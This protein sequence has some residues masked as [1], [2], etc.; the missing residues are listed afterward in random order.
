MRIVIDFLNAPMLEPHHLALALGLASMA[1]EHELWIAASSD[2]RGAFDTLRLS[3]DGLV[4]RHH[5][6]PFALSDDPRLNALLR[7]QALTSLVPD[8]VVTAGT[9]MAAD[10]Q[11]CACASVSLAGTVDELWQRVQD[12]FAS[13]FPPS[14]LRTGAKPR[15]AYVSPLP[16][17]KSGIADYAAELVPELAAYYDI[18]LIVEQER[19]ADARIE[20][21]AQRSAAWLR[22]HARSYDRVLYH[23][24]NSPVHRHMFELIRDVP[25]VVVLHDFYLSN[26]I[27]HLE[28]VDYLPQGF[29][30]ALYESH[31]YSG[32]ADYLKLGRHAAVWQYPL[33]KG[34]LD[35]ATGVIIHSE[36]PKQLAVEWYGDGAA[37]G[38]RSIPLLRGKPEGAVLPQA[39]SAARNRLGLKSGHYVVCSFGMLGKT[40]LNDD[41]L[42]AFLASPLAADPHCSLIFVGENEQGKYGADLNRKIR[43]SKCADRIKITGFVDPATYADYLAGC[44]SAV[45]LRGSSRGETSAAVLDCLLYGVPTIVNAHGSTASIDDSLLL[46]LRDGFARDEL[47]EALWRLRT[48]AG[49]RADLSQRALAYMET[50]HAPAYAGRL[51]HEAIEHFA[52]R[53]PHAGYRQLVDAAAQICPAGQL[54]ALAASI[55]GNR[56]ATA[57]RQLLVDVS[58]LVQSDLK[59]GIQR[60]VRSIVL[61]LIASPPPGFRVEPVFGTGGNRPYHYAR[62]WAMKLVGETG[63]AVEDA[64]AELRPDDIF[65]GL[66]LY[67]SGVAQNERLLQSMRDRG[68]QIYFVIYDLLPMLRPEVFPFGT[69]AGFADF[70]RTVHCVSDGVLCI[71]R[72]VADEYADWVE[73]QGLRRSMPLQLGWFHLGADINASAP[74]TGLPPDAPQVLG[75]L[76]DRPSFLMVGTVEPRKGHAQTLAAFDLLWERGADVN[77]V[78]VGKQ[79]WMVEAV[80][81]RMAAHPEKAKRLFWL[82][83]ISDEMLLKLYAESAALLF[84]S[85]GEGFGLPLIEAAQYG[86]PIIARSIPVFREVAGEHA[87]YFSGLAPENL[88]QAIEEWLDLRRDGRIPLSVG[89]PWLTWS[90]SASQVLAGL[91]DQHW[92]RVLPANPENLADIAPE[93]NAKAA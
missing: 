72:A 21:F 49:L 38:W 25:G 40:K 81:E 85:E 7:R 76:Q 54:P 64:P 84:S 63:L 75:A 5:V 23:F 29:I 71:S 6:R 14:A 73:Q 28:N 44:D 12:A 90:Q 56:P 35:H 62:N 77:L 50:Q 17:E 87:F 51:C 89:M 2:R 19:V 41:L 80:A 16:P 37:E 3:F 88:A 42:D 83:G 27:E 82:A 8:V 74:S 52:T 47:A 22:D 26:V 53:G 11:A 59:T 79:G 55:A 34:V 30:K 66:D 9:F 93:S 1:K 33:N 46:K 20:H 78:I 69:E 39:R 92:Y 60:V 31:G 48:D 68:V 70:L 91:V 24:G 32:L 18:E 10:L 13:L 61:A 45:Q 65:L 67:I 4:P 43:S 36:Y 58:A 57:P 15:L 86:I